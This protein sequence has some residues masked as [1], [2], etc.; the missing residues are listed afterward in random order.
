MLGPPGLQPDPRREHGHGAGRRDQLRA[1]L[2]RAERRALLPV[3]DIVGPWAPSYA[4][5]FG[6]LA[7]ARL[8][9]KALRLGDA[10]DS[11]ELLYLGDPD[12]E[13]EYPVLF[14]DHDTIPMVGVESPSLGVWLATYVDLV[15][16]GSYAG[17]AKATS[18]RL[19]RTTGALELDPLRIAKLPKPVQGKEPGAVKHE[20]LTAA[21]TTGKPRKLTTKQLERA[22]RT[23]AEKNNVRYLKTLIADA[24]SRKVPLDGALLIAAGSSVEVA[25][26]LL[27]AGANVRPAGEW[28]PLHMAARAEPQDRAVT[29]SR[30]LLDRGADPNADMTFGTPLVM[31][32]QRRNRELVRLLLAAGA[33][34][35]YRGRKSVTALEAATR[36]GADEYTLKEFGPVDPDLIALLEDAAQRL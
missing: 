29:L 9:G 23:A 25:E 24:E 20:R 5:A 33:D 27:D 35:T 15:K 32:A 17:Q 2:I 3:M 22:L 18:K 26:L 34:P 28:A 4:E 30:L 1:Q 21:P 7:S 6:L 36:P 11:L 13:G 10:S 8:P 31:A 12:E 14:F 19:F 16:G